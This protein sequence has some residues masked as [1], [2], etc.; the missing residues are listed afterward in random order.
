MSLPMGR[1]RQLRFDLPPHVH[2][3]RGRYYYGRND[4]ALGDDYSVMLRRYAELHTGHAGVGTFGDAVRLYLR[5]ELAGKAPKTQREYS[6]QAAMLVKVFGR[7]RLTEIEPGDISDFLKARNK[8]EKNAKGKVIGGPIAA[9]RDKALFSAIFNFARGA[10]LTNAANPCIGIR[11]KKSHREIYVTDD[12]LASVLEC[13]DEA[14]AT[15]LEIAYRTGADASVVLKLTRAD[16][17]D[18][19][20]WVHRTKTGAKTRVDVV[21]PLEDLL[22]RLKAR[23][24]KT[25]YLVADAHGQPINLQTMRKRFWVARKAAGALFQIR[26]LRA[27]SASDSDDIHSAQVL[28]GHADES[29]T[30]G[31]R[32]KRIGE[33]AKPIMRV[34]KASAK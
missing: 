4:V 33:R 2:V 9:T 23:P 20:L 14:L 24:V 1:R 15:F 7:M 26:D 21:G 11:G 22:E 19:A 31:Y 10:R 8:P 16:V 25:L 5:D 34:V 13:A 17:R 27:K 3:K 32:R 30:A 12:D 29:T 28:L 6:R 18:G